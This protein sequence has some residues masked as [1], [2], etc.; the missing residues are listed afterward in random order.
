MR[1]GSRNGHSH[2]LSFADNPW[3]EKARQFVRT[4]SHLDDMRWGMIK[5]HAFAHIGVSGEESDEGFA[6]LDNDVRDATLNPHA[7]IDLDW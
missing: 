2:G 3:G 1:A 4:T 5:E 6:G 7:F